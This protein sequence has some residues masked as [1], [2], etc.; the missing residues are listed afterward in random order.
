MCG[1]MTAERTQKEFYVKARSHG[2]P[3]T[4]QGGRST[5]FCRRMEEAFI[6]V[7]RVRYPVSVFLGMSGVW[8][9]SRTV[10]IAAESVVHCSA[11]CFVG[12]SYR[13]L[14]IQEKLTFKAILKATHSTK[15]IPIVIVNPDINITY[16]SAFVLR[17]LFSEVSLAYIS[18]R[19]CCKALSLRSG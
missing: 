16:P 5:T 15:S 11:G 17:S 7:Y 3:A 19:L 14:I 13:Y 1:A 2:R 6:Y 18:R 9:C 12:W 4:A 10:E 8:D